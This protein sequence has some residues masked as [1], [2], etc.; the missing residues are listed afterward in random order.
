MFGFQ[1]AWKA[2][3]NEYLSTGSWNRPKSQPCNMWTRSF[4]W[5]SMDANTPHT[6]RFLLPN[7]NQASIVDV[8][9]Q[10]SKTTSLLKKNKSLW[11][12]TLYFPVLVT[13]TRSPI[14]GRKLL[15]W[16]HRWS[17]SCLPFPW[18]LWSAAAC[19]L[20]TQG[21]RYWGPG[22]PCFAPHTRKASSASPQC[23]AELCPWCH[24]FK[25]TKEDLSRPTIKSADG[26]APG[27][28]GDVPCSRFCPNWMFKGATCNIISSLD[29]V[30]LL[31][32]GIQIKLVQSLTLSKSIQA[33]ACF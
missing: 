2:L 5:M 12:Q 32:T 6:L 3:K 7:L 29:V 26:F 16:T 18:W 14:W 8:Q 21:C 27:Q 9:R 28:A 23:S 31:C 13:G 22:V 24:L 19:F 1:T 25:N 33:H 30:V 17:G 11:K 4:T 15:Q 10:S 20:G